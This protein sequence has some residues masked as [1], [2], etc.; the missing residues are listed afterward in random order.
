M[1]FTPIGAEDKEQLRNKILANTYSYKR[2]KQR[3]KY[4]VGAFSMILFVI[5]LSM[6]HYKSAPSS[7]D[8]FVNAANKIDNEGIDEVELILSN[9][10]D[11]YIIENDATITYSGTGEKV[12]IGASKAIQQSAVKNND[13]VVYN[14]LVVPFGKRSKIEL[15]DGSKIWLNSGSKLVYPISFNGEK[16]EVYLEGEAIFEVTHDKNHP[17][18]VMAENHEIEVLGTVFNVSNYSDEDSIR[19]TLKSGSV[20]IN[21]KGKESSFFKSGET[22]RILPGISATYNKHS[23]QI[24]SKKVAIENYFSWRE[25]V[26]IFE[27]NDLRF[28][29]KKL[30][31]YY[32]VPI[33]ITN[34]DLANQTF[35]GYLD[36]KESVENVIQLIGETTD[37]E[38]N[39]KNSNEIIIN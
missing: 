35:T 12:T 39:R 20:Q 21:Y 15:S 3:I 1:N 19:T 30:S 9:S 16:R 5:S 17:F 14:T 27:S 2:R 11:S 8:Q 25:G 37:F 24:S 28:I 22:M 29:M 18:I 7:I 23:Q 36:L 33:V 26:F 4:S 32:N 10:K 6:Y 13:R 38:Y 31:R 34:N